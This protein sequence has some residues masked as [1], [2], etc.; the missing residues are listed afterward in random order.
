MPSSDRRRRRR[1]L[2][3]FFVLAA[4]ILGAGA[5]ARLTALRS[6]PLRAFN[7]PVPAVI[8]SPAPQSPVSFLPAA[9]DPAP[10]PTQAPARILGANT[11]NIVLMGLDSDTDREAAGRGWRSD[12]IAVLVIDV[13]KPSCTVLSVPRD[14][15]ARIE[16]L[17][18]SG[19]SLGWLYNKINSAFNY[20]GGPEE[21]GHENLLASLEQLLF[22]GLESDF[23]LNYYASIDMDG[24]PLFA[25]AV[26]GVPLTLEYDIPGFGKKGETIVLEGE[27]ARTFVRLRHGVT[28]GSDIGRIGRQQAFIRAFASRV[29]QLGAREAVLRL[30][31]T[32]AGNVHTNLNT[33]QILAL[34][35]VLSRLSLKNVEFKT[36][37]GRCKTID[38]RSYYVPN[39]R[40][41]RTLALELWGE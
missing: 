6:D 30:W 28:G 21:L 10:T 36:L 3:A 20:G 24:I 35:E 12:T 1:M 41:V 11:I 15:R 31:T 26:D 22:D 40:D 4:L 38:G 25:D 14:T 27:Q 2:L 32:L 39:T 18:D 13:E 8:P 16:R 23:H 33:E 5:A 17:S 37:P 7:T 29:Q 34:G 9:L 19:K